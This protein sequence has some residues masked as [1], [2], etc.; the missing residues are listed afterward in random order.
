MQLSPSL[1]LQLPIIP[2]VIHCLKVSGL[3]VER[4]VRTHSDAKVSF[5]FF[6]FLSVSA[7]LSAAYVFSFS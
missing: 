4:R 5:F 3:C 1:T 2:S 6:F 7:F